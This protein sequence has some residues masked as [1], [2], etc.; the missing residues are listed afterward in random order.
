MKGSRGLPPGRG[1]HPPQAVA[2]LRRRKARDDKP[3][4]VA[5]G[6]AELGVTLPYSPL[7]HPLMTGADRPLVPTSGNLSDETI[8]YSD[9]DAVTRLGP[10]VD[11]LLSH[12]RPIHIRCDDSVVRAT[13]AGIQ[14]LRRSRGYAPEPIGL[15][16][17][18][19][20]PLPAAAAGLTG[21]RGGG[22]HYR[23]GL[24]SMEVPA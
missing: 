14:V 3:P 4:G 10:L 21:D 5:P 2:E 8:A 12:N 15:P 24:M 16:Q 23:R 17:P 20:R 7:H 22:G 19:L 9:P 13:P 18:A 11:E 1:R 6:L